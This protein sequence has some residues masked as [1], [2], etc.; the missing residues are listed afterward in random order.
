MRE[1]TII[2]G[3]LAGLTLGIALRQYGVPVVIREKSG[4]SCRMAETTF[5]ALA[6]S[7][8]R[9]FNDLF[10]PRPVPISQNAT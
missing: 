8:A 5:R 3:G 2:G 10:R 4:G 9:V 7:S 1:L 6:S